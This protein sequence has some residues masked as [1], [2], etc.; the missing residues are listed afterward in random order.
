MAVALRRSM[1]VLA[2]VSLLIVATA[3]MALAQYPPGQTYRVTAVPENPLAGDTVTVM[4]VGAAPG[5]T[6]NWEASNGGVFASGSVV[7]DSNGEAQFTFV[8]PADMPAG[9][10]IEV[11]VGGVI[12]GVTSTLITVDL[13]G[14]TDPAPDPDDGTDVGDEIEET[15]GDDVATDVVDGTTEADQA[16]AAASPD[17]L[18]RTGLQTT[19]Y[20]LL[21]LLLIGLGAAAV[22][23]A[24]NRERS[25]VEI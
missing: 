10:S 8:I 23:G 5:E 13:G 6:L 3:T 15:D 11:V 4:V 22:L 19:S 17:E 24:R 16:A 25:R 7:A 21:A 20:L 18:S 9:T 2:I 1:H 14:V 12:S